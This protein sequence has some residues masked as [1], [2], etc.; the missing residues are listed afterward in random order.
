M[1][2]EP[3]PSEAL[4][5]LTVPGCGPTTPP[6]PPAEK[7]FPSAEHQEDIA[8]SRSSSDRRHEHDDSPECHVGCDVRDP[9]P[10]DAMFAELSQTVTGYDAMVSDSEAARVAEHAMSL[11]DGLRLYPKAIAWSA[12]LSLT[13]V[14]EGYDLAIVNGFFALPQFRRRYGEL[15]ASSGY[16]IST[17]WQSA[18]T[19][20]AVSGEIIG[21]FANGQSSS[22]NTPRAPPVLKFDP[23]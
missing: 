5:F 13:L 2:G 12:L 21:L 7:T 22:R 16:Q 4:E 19:N 9:T 11:R 17:K 3:H 1:D 8:K 14:M 23:P 18:L 15:T 20:G 10:L 6:S